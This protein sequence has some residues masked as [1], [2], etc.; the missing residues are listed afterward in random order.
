MARRDQDEFGT[1]WGI[2]KKVG[3]V[4]RITEAFQT[5]KTLF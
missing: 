2:K 3:G 1:F 4:Q 5:D